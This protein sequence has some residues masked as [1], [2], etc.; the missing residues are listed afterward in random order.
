MKIQDTPCEFDA[1]C[2]APVEL[3]HKKLSKDTYEW[4][5]FYVCLNKHY[6][7]Q[8]IDIMVTDEYDHLPEP[9]ND[10]YTQDQLPFADGDF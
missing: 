1:N 5:G 2:N 10:D 9:D 3:L 6:Y 8:K 7:M 4:L